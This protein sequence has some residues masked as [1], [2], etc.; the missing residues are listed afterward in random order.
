MSFN[1]R[2]LNHWIFWCVILAVGSTVTYGAGI[3]ADWFS[4][5]AGGAIW[6]AFSLG[7]YGALLDS[8]LEKRPIF[9]FSH[10]FSQPSYISY[11]LPI[12]IKVT[13]RG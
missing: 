7:T 1:L 12:S 9:S 8:I 13:P 2:V 3:E 11:I 6:G 5:I 4:V 10:G